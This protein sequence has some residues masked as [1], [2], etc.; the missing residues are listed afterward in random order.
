VRE[1]EIPGYVSEFD[2]REAAAA[3]A[4]SW[5]TWDTLSRDERIMAV[6][7]TRMRRLIEIHRDDAAYREAKRRE[8]MAKNG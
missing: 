2:E 4:V 3:A 5:D 6:A 1:A 7:H 8:A